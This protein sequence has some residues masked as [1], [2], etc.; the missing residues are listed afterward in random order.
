MRHKAKFLSYL[1]LTGATAYLGLVSHALIASGYVNALLKQEVDVPVQ[2]SLPDWPPMQNSTLVYTQ[3]PGNN[4]VYNSVLTCDDKS[5]FHFSFVSTLQES[6]F[7]ATGSDE[8]VWGIFAIPY[9]FLI[10]LGIHL[11]ITWFLRH[12][13][14]VVATKSMY[15]EYHY[16]FATHAFFASVFAYFIAV[17]FQS[18][19]MIW[20]SEMWGPGAYLNDS[21]IGGVCLALLFWLS[22]LIY[23]YC[24]I[25]TAGIRVCR[26]PDAKKQTCIRCGYQLGEGDG[27][28]PECDLEA[29]AFIRSKWRVNHWY[30]AAMCVVT[31][32][33][34]VLVASVYS[35]FH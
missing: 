32:F 29:G 24:V 22:V 18:G 23:L 1:L 12:F 31:F 33:S 20:A 16:P 21:K 15:I 25:G 30:L 17:L 13:V 9:P 14:R 7:I 3:V 19:R 2:V 35:V 28:C 4:G 27:R 11:L 5:S 8:R 34:P 6:I 26:S 10:P